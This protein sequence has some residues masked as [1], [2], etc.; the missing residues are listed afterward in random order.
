MTSPLKY[1]TTCVACFS[2]AKGFVLGSIEGRCAVKNVD[3]AKDLIN[4]PD[5]FCFK[6]HRV[7][8]TANPSKPY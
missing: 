4:P 5:D 8:D 6:S 1:P 7:D 3:L 2:D